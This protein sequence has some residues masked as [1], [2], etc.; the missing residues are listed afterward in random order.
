MNSSSKHGIYGDPKTNFFISISVTE[1]EKLDQIKVFR[2]TDV[3]LDIQSSQ[4]L[5]KIHIFIVPDYE[6]ATGKFTS[7]INE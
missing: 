4:T 6:S 3:N 7:Y 5:R 1:M 2:L